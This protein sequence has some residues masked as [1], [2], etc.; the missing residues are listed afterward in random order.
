V[1]EKALQPR[2]RRPAYVVALNLLSK[3]PRLADL[4]PRAAHVPRPRPARRRALPAAG[5]HAG[6]ADQAPRRHHRR[7]AHPAARQ[8]RPPRRHHARR[9][10]SVQVASATPNPRREGAPRDRDSTADLLDRAGGRR[11]TSSWC[12]AEARGGRRIR[13]SPS[14]RTSP[15][16][17]TASTNSASPSRSS[18]SRAPTASS[19]SCPACRTWPRPRTSS[20]APRR[21]KSAWSTTPRARCSGARRQVPRHRIYERTRRL[22]A[23][24]EEAGRADRRP[25]H[26]R[27]ARLRR[28]DPGTRGAPDPRFA[29]ARIF[30][31]HPRERRQAHGHPAVRE[32][33][34]RSRHRAGDPQRD[35]RRP[36]ADHRPHEHREANDVALLLRAGS[37]A[38]PMDI[39]EE[40]TV[41]PS[42]GAENIRRASTRRCGA[43]SPSPCS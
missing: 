37:L 32:G 41:G 18:S 13:D 36:L 2:R 6:R 12:H 7:P 14:S 35:R 5:R 15:P 19:C 9:R 33:Q 42:L 38:A 40:R 10:Q 24:G 22:A 28:P 20:A 8:E 43:S 34:G 39:I 17:T 26:R 29:G 3:S 4:D 25:P 27:P 11:P 16:C 23:A 30:N 31:R 21:W 1:I